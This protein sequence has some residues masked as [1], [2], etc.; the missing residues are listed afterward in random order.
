MKQTA[1]KGT[2]TKHAGTTKHV[3]GKG[4][5]HPA[6]AKKA[7]THHHAAKKQ[8]VHTAAKGHKVAK[9]RKLAWADVPVRA[10]ITPFAS[11]GRVDGAAAWAELDDVA[12]CPV[13]ALAESLKLSGRL[14]GADDV[15]TLYGHL[16]R[17]ADAGATILATLEAAAEY[18]LAGVRPLWFGEIAS[19]TRGVEPPADAGPLRVPPFTGSR[20]PAATLAR[21]RPAGTASISLGASVILGLELPEGPHAVL[22]ERGR[23]WSWSQPWPPAAFPDAVIEEAWAVTWP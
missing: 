5:H 18:G 13:L 23:W 9:P 14:C 17:D 7:A 12:C 16:T 19:E 21:H 15:L 10:V 1:H 20:S 4:K 2:T 22:A 3:A 11:R 6:K 8:P